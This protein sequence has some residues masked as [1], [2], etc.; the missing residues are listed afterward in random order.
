MTLDAGS[1]L[2]NRFELVREVGRGS[3]GNVWLAMHL[4]LGVRCAVK[5]MTSEAMRHPDYAA[6]FALEARAIAH[7]NSPNIVRVLDYDVDDGVPFIA[8]EWLQGEDSR[9]AHRSSRPPRPCSHPSYRLAGR[10]RSREGARGRHRAQGFEAREHLPRGRRRG[11]DCEARR[12]RDRDT[13]FVRARWGRHASAA[14]C[15]SW[16]ARPPT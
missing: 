4:T 6:R 12:L 14:G 9:R 13:D 10:P 11:R 5:F 3:M 2:A 8:M 1:I 16:S 15:M 7:L